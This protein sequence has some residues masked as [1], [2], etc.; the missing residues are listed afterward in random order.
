MGTDETN[1]VHLQELNEQIYEHS[2]E[3]AAIN[4]TLSLLRKL[5]QISLQSLDLKS[6]SAKVSETIRTDLN[7][8]VVGIFHYDSEEDVLTPLSFSRSGRLIAALGP[9]MATLD[10]SILKNASQLGLLREVIVNKK[11]VI[12]ADYST[13]WRGLLPEKILDDAAVEA[14]MKTV[15]LYPMTASGKVVGVL[16][17]GINRS[18]DTLTK[19]EKDSIMSFID[20][21]SVAI[22]KALLYRELTAAN[23]QLQALDKARSEFIT[24]ASHQL[25]TPPATLKWYL[26]ALLSGDYGQLSPE[27][28]AIVSKAQVTNNSLIS[29]IDD[30]LNASRIERGKMEFLFEP[31]D[32]AAI[33][34]MAVDQL[35]PQAYMKGLQLV[36][37]PPTH[38]LPQIMA[39]QEKLRQVVNNMIDN[40]IK[41]TTAGVVTVSVFE[42]DR[43]VCVSV[44]DTGKGIPSDMLKMLFE[45]YNRGK[46]SAMQATG[47]GLGMYLAKIV[48]EQHKG[49]IW[50]ESPGI[51]KGAT[52]TFSIPIHSGVT[53]TTV[54]DLT[55]S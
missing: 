39:D 42:K 18:F 19:F 49:N 12:S 37:H 51:N 36:Y 43:N 24:I 48:V 13:V 4:K 5:Y 15:L 30:L 20:V 34:K 9:N 28:S 26:G 14:H 2:H 45:K 23:S 54:L 32:L 38:P 33:T 31:T 8:E 40:S 53:E 44:S 7:M 29:L 6:L 25:R 3:L 16:F 52:F 50:A 11:P 35:V 46:D 27:V 17:L 22:D 10:R 41:Y 21:V 47:L 1:K 55:K